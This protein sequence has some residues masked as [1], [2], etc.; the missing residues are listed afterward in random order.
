MWI[1]S[2][3]TDLLFLLDPNTSFA[4]ASYWIILGSL[5]AAVFAAPASLKAYAKI[6]GRTPAKRLASSEACAYL[7]A[8]QL[9]A[10]NFFAR[11]GLTGGE[12]D[13]VSRG[14]MILTV[15]GVASI[16]VAGYFGGLFMSRTIPSDNLSTSPPGTRRAA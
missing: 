13:T 12:A 15:L 7:V 4:R 9:F 14:Q 2:L 16:A 5:L 1:L 10:L 6:P 8:T 11:H 3:G